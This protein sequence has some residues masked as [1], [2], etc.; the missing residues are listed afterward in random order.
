MAIP[1]IEH[2]KEQWRHWH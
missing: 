2:T 1:L